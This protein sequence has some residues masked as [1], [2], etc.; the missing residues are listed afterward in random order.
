MESVEEI[1][2]NFEAKVLVGVLLGLGSRNNCRIV[3]QTMLSEALV[4][5]EY[6]RETRSLG[7]R[8]IQVVRDKAALAASDARKT[9]ADL[10][11]Q[12]Q[13]ASSAQPEGSL[14]AITQDGALSTLYLQLTYGL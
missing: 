3:S 4:E 13:E 10:E 9:V 1:Q 11:N 5:L 8:A 2:V 6:L 14:P 7:H 12:L